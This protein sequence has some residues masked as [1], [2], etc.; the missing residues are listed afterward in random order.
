MIKEDGMHC[1]A[2]IVVASEG[3]A[4]V[5]HAATHM[6]A[7]QMGTDPFCRTDKLQCIIVMLFD[8]CGNRQDIG[9]EDDVQRIHPYL[10]R[11]QLISPLRDLYP[12][13]IGRC[14][15]LLIKAHHDNSSAETLP[16]Q[17]HARER[18]LRL[19]SRIWS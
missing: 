2:D 14:L 16:R 15:P 4:E 12:T 5:A 8:T 7:F 11:Q 18:R 13:L 10:L 19:P 1:F 9:V 17:Q 3:E 6:R